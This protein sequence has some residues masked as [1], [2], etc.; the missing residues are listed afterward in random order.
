MIL[1][2]NMVPTYSSRGCPVV[3]PVQIRMVLKKLRFSLEKPLRAIVIEQSVK[4]NLEIDIKH[5]KKLD[6]YY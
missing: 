6:K 5:C 4:I 1:K 3:S 2:K